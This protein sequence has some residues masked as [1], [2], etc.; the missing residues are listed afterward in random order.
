MIKQTLVFA[1]GAALCAAPLAAQG[2]EHKM[3]HKKDGKMEHGA[4]HAVSGWKELD[5]YHMLMMATW[6]PAKDKNDM[7]PIRAQATAMVA[8]AKLVAASKAP[9]ACQK[10]EFVKMQAALPAETA[11][12]AAMVTAT[13]SDAD[14]KAGLSKLHDQFDVLEG[15][16]GMKS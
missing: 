8:S 6:H 1:L 4:D 3:D 9:M 5:A 7:A 10:P 13:A 16:A 12:V 14:L 2:A 15:C 11:K